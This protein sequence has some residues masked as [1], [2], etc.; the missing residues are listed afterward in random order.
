[1]AGQEEISA[2]VI[3]FQKALSSREPI[4]ELLNMAKDFIRKG[5]MESLSDIDMMLIDRFIE[6][7]R[8]G[9]IDDLNE[10]QEAVL[11]FTDSKVADR[12]KQDEE[13][14]VVMV[15]HNQCSHLT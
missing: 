1:M 14:E 15:C 5:E 2:S 10:F 12:L 8:K 9:T 3:I 4:K 11:S 7:L 13:G 6:Y